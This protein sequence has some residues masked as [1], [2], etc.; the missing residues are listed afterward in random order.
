MKNIFPYLIYVCVWKCLFINIY[1]ID[2]FVHWFYFLSCCLFQKLCVIIM[3]PFQFSR[4]FFNP[5]CIDSRLCLFMYLVYLFFSIL[6]FFKLLSKVPKRPLL[7]I[8]K[9]LITKIKEKPLFQSLLTPNSLTK[10]FLKP[11]LIRLALVSAYLFMMTLRI[12]RR[13]RSSN[14]IAF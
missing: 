8:E 2:A 12:L 11:F 9:V 7:V 10:I 1:L 13:K 6:I 5:L 4:Q 3:A 14:L